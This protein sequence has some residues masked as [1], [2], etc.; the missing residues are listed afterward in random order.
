MRVTLD[1]SR[2]V[3]DHV[4]LQASA[5]IAPL[6]SRVLR[7][8]CRE[9]PLVVQI[10]ACEPLA[11]PEPEPTEPVPGAL[12]RICQ[13]LTGTG[14]LALLRHPAQSV[15][16]GRMALADGPRLLDIATPEDEACW[17]ELLSLA[18]PV[19]GVRGQLACEVLSPRPASV[20]SALAYG[21]FVCE[22]G[23]ALERL[24]EDRVH[25]AWRVADPACRTSVIIRGGF[26]ATTIVSAE[27]AWQDQGHEGYVRLVLRTAGG[28][29]WTQPR[30][31]APQR[32]PPAA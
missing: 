6:W 19:Y 14:A 16:A 3:D 26:E 5:P 25:V 8:T 31:I 28:A 17:D 24:L 18:R 13:A 29:C 21:M 30:F 10:L 2:V 20:L 32:A 7:W 12:A 1:P 11:L 23:L 15:G 27:G 22:E 4:L 9:V